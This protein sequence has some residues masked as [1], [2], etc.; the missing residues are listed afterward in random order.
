M[1]RQSELSNH[2]DGGFSSLA[3]AVT[4]RLLDAKGRPLPAFEVASRNYVVGEQGQHY[5]IEVSN[6]TAERL[7][8]VATVDG[9]DVVDGDEGS[10]RKRGYVVGS[11]DTLQ[12]EGYRRT[13]DTVAAFRFGRVADSYAAKTGKPRN[14]GVIGV[15]VFHERGSELPWTSDEVQ[16]RHTAEPFPARF[17]PPPPR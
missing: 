7:E 2:G 13:E 6:Q 1:A 14:V 5:L 9:L 16:F 3:G 15:A 10:I 12:I 17:A 4:V 11:F 8:V